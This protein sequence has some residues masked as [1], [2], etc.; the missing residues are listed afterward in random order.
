MSHDALKPATQVALGVS[1]GIAALALARDES[2]IALAVG[3]LISYGVTNPGWSWFRR[4]VGGPAAPGARAAFLAKAAASGAML[5]S[6]AVLSCYE[7]SFAMRV[8]LVVCTL[9]AT[10]IASLFAGEKLSEIL[11]AERMAND[12]KG[13]PALPEDLPC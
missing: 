1:L 9:V 7:E 5:V 13:N 8:F 3:F 2:W 6:A 11:T 4:S 12:A 10:C